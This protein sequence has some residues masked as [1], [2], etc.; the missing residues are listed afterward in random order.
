[1]AKAKAEVESLPNREISTAELAAIVGKSTRWIRQLT[2][3]GTLKQVGRGKYILTDAV[4]AYIEHASGGK[5]EDNKP[6]YIDHR[7][8]HERIKTEKASLELAEMQGK[9]HAAEDVEAVM[10]DMLGSFRQRMRAIPMRMAPE[11]VAQPDLNIIKG[12]L[13]AAIDEALAEL[14]DYDPERF[15]EERAR[16][17]PDV[18]E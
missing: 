10:N 6:R 4:Q 7:T 16:T 13:A 3:E 1:M 18:G 9:L 15:A 17:D 5:E 14:A 12:R 11:L 2:G 8:E